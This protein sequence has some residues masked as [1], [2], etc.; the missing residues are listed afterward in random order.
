MNQRKTIK[1][2]DDTA[3]SRVIFLDNM[4]Y[5]L[6][7]GVVLQHASNSY[8]GLDWWPVKDDASVIVT[9]LNTFLDA[10]LMPSL[11]FVAGYFAVPSMRPRTLFSFLR[12]KAKRIGVPWLVC[13]LTI[14]PLLPAVYH[15]T[16]DGFAVR[17]SFWDIY[18]ALFRNAAELDIGFL[19]PMDMVMQNNLFYQRYMWFLG[20]LMLFFVIFG[21][22]YQARPVWFARKLPEKMDGKTSYFSD[23]KL[24]LAIGIITSLGSTLLILIMFL[25]ADGISDPETWL[26][27]GNLVQFRLSRIFLYSTYFFLG[28]VAFRNRW[29]DRGRLTRHVRVKSV[30]TAF[31]VFLLLTV[32]YQMMHGPDHLEQ[33]FGL[34]FWLV[35]NGVC[36]SALGFFLSL[37][38][39][40]LSKP[41]PFH[42]SMA[43]NSYEIYLS[44]YLF[45][46]LFQLALLPVAWMPGLLKFTVVSAAGLI[47][48]VTVSRY[49]V[50]R[51]TGLTVVILFGLLIGLI[52][53]YR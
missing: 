10:F 34:L 33:V 49:L 25:L 44:H 5:L 16:R 13:S 37:C 31:L 9:W 11:F 3:G 7:V 29:F 18:K 28:I 47:S 22:L 38:F 48:S 51:H 14:C 27:L 40:Y 50:R 6:V 32:K 45:I 52:L 36:I 2:L 53:F 39:R 19:P 20:V 26:S 15:F 4:R 24:M 17:Q 30:V 42:K 1:A 12:A 35:L 8:M 43:E 46:I 41:R 23:L 21:C